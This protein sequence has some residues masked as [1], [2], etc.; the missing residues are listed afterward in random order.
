MRDRP[1]AGSPS[2]SPRASRLWPVRPAPYRRQPSSA[3]RFSLAS[4]HPGELLPMLRSYFGLGGASRLG[5]DRQPQALRAFH[6]DGAPATWPSTSLY[7]YLRT[8]YGH[9]LSLNS[10]YDYDL[11]SGS[12]WAVKF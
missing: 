1:D 4:L 11:S 12:I 7:A 8:R 10:I 2:R 5:L 3:P 9:A 6:R